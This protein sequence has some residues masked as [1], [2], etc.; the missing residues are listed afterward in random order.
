ML[1]HRRAGPPAGVVNAEAPHQ[2]R[3]GLSGQGAIRFRRAEALVG[4]TGRDLDGTVPVCCPRPQTLTTQRIRAQVRGAAHGA[5]REASGRSAADPLNRDGQTCAHTFSPYHDPLDNLPDH[6]VSVCHRRGRGLP[7]CRNLL[8]QLLDGVSRCLRERVGRRVQQTR[9]ILVQWSLRRERVCPV[10]GQLP[11]HPAR[12]GFD[13][14]LGTRGPLTVVGRAR[15]AL[16]P[17]PVARLTLVLQASGGRQRQRQRGRFTGFEHPRCDEGIERFTGALWALVTPVVDHRTATD[18]ALSRSWPPIAALQAGVARAADDYPGQPCRAMT[19]RAKRS[20][21]GPVRGEA[22]QMLG[23]LRPGARGGHTIL[24]HHRITLWRARHTPTTGAS[25]RLFGPID[26]ASSI[27]I[28][29]GIEGVFEE[30]LP[31]RA[32]GTAPLQCPVGRS[33]APAYAALDA[34]LPAITP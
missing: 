13:Q 11:R 15:Q 23:V 29:P 12:L 32:R 9:V 30:R 28:G 18:I 7:K 2:L 33:V 14:P 10:L 24:P 27:G 20:G 19:H 25:R 3:H 6:L 34:L 1:A 26:L 16:L 5:C 4:Q 22:G 8:R 31:G 17:Q 21:M